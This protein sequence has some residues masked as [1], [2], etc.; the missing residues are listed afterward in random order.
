VVSV[1]HED[2]LRGINDID[3]ADTEFAEFVIFET[4]FTR[5][6]GALVG[7]IDEKWG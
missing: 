4:A 5:C 6:L 1:T 2:D 7:S 3:T